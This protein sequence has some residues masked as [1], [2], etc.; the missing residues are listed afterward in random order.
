MRRHLEALVMFTGADIHS[1][2][3][4]T[5]ILRSGCVESWIQDQVDIGALGKDS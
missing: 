1:S 3:A 5:V 4:I 2:V